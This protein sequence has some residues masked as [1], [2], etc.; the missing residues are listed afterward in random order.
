LEYYE[1]EELRK[2]LESIF[3]VFAGLD[4]ICFITDDEEVRDLI[5]EKA[6]KIVNDLRQD[7]VVC[8]GEEC[9][10]A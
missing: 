3:P 10:F 9:D 1:E 8:L 4:S 6:R 2:L 7:I 5:E